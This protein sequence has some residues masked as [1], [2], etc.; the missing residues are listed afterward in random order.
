MEEEKVNVEGVRADDVGDSNAPDTPMADDR[1]FQ[2][3]SKLSGDMQFEHN[4]GIVPE[5]DDGFDVGLADD[6]LMDGFA[7]Q[8]RRQRSRSDISRHHG[9]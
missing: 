2:P 1:H 4:P 3:G 8:S 5:D 6:T 7:L 9:F